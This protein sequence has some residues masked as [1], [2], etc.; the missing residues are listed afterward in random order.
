MAGLPYNCRCFTVTGNVAGMPNPSATGNIG[1]ATIQPITG[2]ISGNPSVYPPGSAAPLIPHLTQITSSASIPAGTLIIA[3][4][5]GGNGGGVT[6]TSTFTTPINTACVNAIPDVPY[7][8]G[9]G[10]GGG[11]GGGDPYVIY[12]KRQL[13]LSVSTDSQNNTILNFTN[14]DGSF[15]GVVLLIKGADGQPGTLPNYGSSSTCSNGG[16]IYPSPTSG[17]GGNGGYGFYVGN[18]GKNGIYQPFSLCPGVNGGTTSVTNISSASGG[19]SILGFAQVRADYN[20]CDGRPPV[21]GGGYGTGGVGCT[22]AG[23]PPADPNYGGGSFVGA[24]Y[25]PTSTVLALFGISA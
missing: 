10:G 24:Y 21:T 20:S 5:A 12:V 13:G 4:A 16:G 6:P 1:G 22:N 14:P 25:N 18:N 2:T 11:G 9:A 17:I 8:I 3:T 23:S 7:S 15:A 19:A